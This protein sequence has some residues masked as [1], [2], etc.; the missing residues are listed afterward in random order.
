MP[1]YTRAGK[2]LVP[3][4]EERFT[5]AMNEGKFCHRSHRGFAS[6]LYHTGVRQSEARRAIKEQFSLQGDLIFFEVGKRLKRGKHTSPLKIPIDKPFANE[7]WTSVENTESGARV[8]PYCRKTGYNIVE[9][10]LTYPHH[11]RLSKITSLFE[12]GF[13]ISQVQNWTGLSLSALN[14]YI[15]IVDTD[16]M[17]RA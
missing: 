11:L 12:K 9:R 14:F 6:L 17:A 5:A 1:N 3:I 10:I 8:W 16:A 4:S 2:Q 15:G 7:I 13:T